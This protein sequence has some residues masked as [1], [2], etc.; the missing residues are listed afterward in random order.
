M[1]CGFQYLHF[2]LRNTLNFTLA[3]LQ[4]FAGNSPVQ[5]IGVSILAGLLYIFL[6]IQK[7]QEMQG[8]KKQ[9]QSA[10]ILTCAI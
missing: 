9:K 1:V 10:S 6:A 2:K 3:K 7:M 4:Y 8:A 5:K